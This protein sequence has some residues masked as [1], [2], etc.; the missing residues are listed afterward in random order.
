MTLIIEQFHNIQKIPFKKQLQLLSH[1][2]FSRT[3]CLQQQ[4]DSLNPV[5]NDSEHGWTIVGARS[6]TKL[7]MTSHQ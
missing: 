7:M 4:I 1:M 3:L 2:S 6:L 5:T